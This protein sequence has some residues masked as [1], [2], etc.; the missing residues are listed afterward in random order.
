MLHNSVGHIPSYCVMLIQICMVG[1]PTF[2]DTIIRLCTHIWWRS[3]VVLEE[4]PT[5]MALRTLHGQ[6]LHRGNRKSSC[7]RLRIRAVAQKCRLNPIAWWD[8]FLSHWTTYFVGILQI[9]GKLFK[10]RPSFIVNLIFRIR[11]KSL[12]L[13]GELRIIAGQVTGGGASAFDPIIC[14]ANTRT[15]VCKVL[16]IIRVHALYN[17]SRLILTFLLTIGLGA[18]AIGCVCSDLV[19]LSSHCKQKYSGPWSLFHHPSQRFQTSYCKCVWLVVQKVFIWHL[20]SKPCHLPRRCIWCL[21]Y[22]FRGR[23]TYPTYQLLTRALIVSCHTVWYVWCHVIRYG[24]S[25]ERTVCVWRRRL[26]TDTLEMFA[27]PN[28]RVQRYGGRFLKRR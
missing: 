14:P 1:C 5:F 9:S 6:S 3:G 11:C 18:I 25:M 17:R 4:A 21:K 13:F 22:T 27:K 24:S 26:L 20:N 10:F 8:C 2:S 16:M 19:Y 23:C 7:N 15:I 28:E 12:R